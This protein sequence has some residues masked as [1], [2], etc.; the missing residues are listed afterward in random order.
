MERSTERELSYG[1]FGHDGLLM[2]NRR[3]QRRLTDDPSCPRC[4][5][6]VES[7]VHALRDCAIVL[8]LWESLMDGN[9]WAEFFSLNRIDWL[10]SNLKKSFAY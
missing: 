8:D 1:F 3:N 6:H 9:L 2:N 7:Y 10:Q 5:V 4:R